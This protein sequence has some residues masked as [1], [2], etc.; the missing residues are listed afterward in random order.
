MFTVTATPTGVTASATP[1]SS[2][3]SPFDGDWHLLE[4]VL[5]LAALIKAVFSYW[6][7]YPLFDAIHLA[8][9]MKVQFNNGV[10]RQEVIGMHVQD[11]IDLRHGGDVREEL[12]AAAQFKLDCRRFERELGHSMSTAELQH[13][14]CAA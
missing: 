4:S 7:H 8:Q 1:S 9:A 5:V 2:E 14:V 13:H 11:L 6:S 10:T 12:L 3:D